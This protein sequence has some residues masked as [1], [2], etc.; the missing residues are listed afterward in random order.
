MQRTFTAAERK[1]WLE[2]EYVGPATVGD[3][4]LLGVRRLQD[5]AR[6]KPEALYEE[7]AR[8]T[9]RRQDPCVLDVFA[10]LVHRARGGKPRPWW[11]FSRERLAA[12]ENRLAGP[13]KARRR[14]APARRVSAARGARA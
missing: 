13:R 9:G 3:L 7:L 14:A 4:E 11:E 2:H 1:A 6:R 10:M 12:A 8:R 5:L